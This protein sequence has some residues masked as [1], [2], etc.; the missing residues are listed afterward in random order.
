MVTLFDLDRNAIPAGASVP[1]S[2]ALETDF[3]AAMIGRVAEQES[4]RKEIHRPAS[5]THKWWAQRLGTVFRGILAS[6]V[7]TSPREAED[8]YSSASRLDGLVV[9]DPFAG[10]GT[11]LVEA[12]KLGADVVGF[13]INPVA[14]L[15]QRQALARW[16]EAELVAAFKQV[17][18]DCRA[19]IDS[20]HVN[21]LGET[22]LYYFWVANASCPS[23]AGNVELFTDYVFAKHAYPRTHPIARATCPNCHGIINVDL[24]SDDKLDCGSCGLV[25]ESTGPVKG[26]MMICASGHA[27]RVVEALAGKAPSYSLF[28]KMVLGRDGVKRYEAIDDF[29]RD[30]YSTAAGTLSDSQEKIVLPSGALENGHNTRQALRWGFASWTQFFNH[31]Q[32]LSLG[33]LGRAVRDLDCS[34]AHREAMVA[35]F[36]GVLEFNNLFC[37]FKGE[38]TGA[39]RHMFSHHVL[40]PERVPLEA[41]PWGTPSS[42]GSFSTLF[43]SRIRRALQYK[44][45]PHDIVATNIGT[46]RVFGLSEALSRDLSR[47]WEVTKSGKRSMVKNASSVRTGLPDASVDLIVTD[48]PFMDNVHYS[49]LADFF[50]AWLQRLAPYE[51]YPTKATTRDPEEVQNTEPRAFGEAIAAVWRECARVLRNTGLLAFTFH[52][53]K[54]QGWAE[55]MSAL[56]SADLV[57]TSVQPVKAEMSTAAPKSGVREPSNL[58]SIVV[59]RKAASVGGVALPTSANSAAATAYQRL[60]R[61]AESGMTVGAADCRSVVWGSVL[62]LGTHPIGMPSIEI[63]ILDAQCLAEHYVEKLV[64][65]CALGQRTSEPSSPSG[66]R[67]IWNL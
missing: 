6:A 23:C 57:V 22:V 63:L 42:S 46:R 19:T 29:D 13:D 62:A 61:L 2:S 21:V 8:F 16:D 59:C 31:R 53:S 18:Q 67:Q 38:G 40:K 66:V 37:S 39:V 41:H 51:G 20:L 32:L 24:G 64:T 36:S 10:S 4:W 50:H 26:Q 7:A 54:L 12:V 58:D 33:L 48:P 25:A 56:A 28:A 35:L 5:H 30:L 52:Q 60:K 27:S 43:E 1:P 49:E 45:N 9:L 15:V 65:D 47:T 3:P 44:L 17:E 34:P 11:T 55:L 14:T